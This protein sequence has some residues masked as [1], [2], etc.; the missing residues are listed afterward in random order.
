MMIPQMHWNLACCPT[1]SR[2]RTAGAFRAERDCVSAQLEVEYES[3]AL[4]DLSR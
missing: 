1:T 4:A 2:P 3:G